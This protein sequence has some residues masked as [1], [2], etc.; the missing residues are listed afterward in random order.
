M[1]NFEEARKGTEEMFAK[2]QQP[3]QAEEQ[4]EQPTE[5]AL[6]EENGDTQNETV[7]NAVTTAETAAQAAAEAD[8]ARQQ[9]EGRYEE[10]MQELEALKAKNAELQGTI[11]ELSKRNEESIIEEALEPP[12]LNL[13]DLAFADGETLKAAQAKYAADMA[14]YS[15]KQI[16]KEIEPLINEARA[17]RLEKEKSGLIKDLAGTKEFS[18]IEDYIPQIENIM[19]N[20]TSLWAENAPLEQK[21]ITAY[22]IAK[23]V[24]SMRNPKKE[25]GTEELMKLYEENADFR[26]MVDKRRLEE[27]KKS[28]Q[29][30][31]LSASS[32]AVNA[33]LN[34]KERPKNFDEA[35]E[36]T[37]KMFGLD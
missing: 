34:I 5:Q 36:R 37:R 26:D 22:A 28:Q 15:K 24:D 20:N 10:V 32:G 33:A 3:E 18:D 31:P 19:A 1:D 4:Q 2:Q 16:L 21:Y 35:S 8:S 13:N 30:P 14:D 11:E 12:T 25:P 27:A 7:E 6:S 23:G 9:A 29:V 17:G